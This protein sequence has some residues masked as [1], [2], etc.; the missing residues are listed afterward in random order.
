M[1]LKD[2]IRETLI[3]ITNGVIEAQ[4]FVKGTGCYIN[5]EGFNL[6]SSQIKSGFNKQYRSVQK[7]K[8]SI[9]I[10]VLENTEKK[11]GIGVMAAFLSAGTSS[12]N[13]DSNSTLNH[14]E[15]EIPI[16]LPVMDV[17]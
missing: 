7:I 13:S 17:E 12:K 3:Q 10:N 16:S 5:P 11:A 9:A 8:L 2:F 14:I 15:F 6:D 1:E 4:E